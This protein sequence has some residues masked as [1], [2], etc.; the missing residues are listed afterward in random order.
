MNAYKYL[1]FDRHFQMF[2]ICYL[3]NGYTV[4]DMLEFSRETEPIGVCVGT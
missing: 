2:L 4:S 1:Q 3:K